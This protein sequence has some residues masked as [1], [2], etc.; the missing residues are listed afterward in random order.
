MTTEHLRRNQLKNPHA[1]LAHP[2]PRWARTGFSM[3]LR[4][5]ASALEHGL[6]LTVKLS[7]P[8]LLTNLH[9]L[10]HTA[11]QLQGALATQ[12]QLQDLILRPLWTLGIYDTGFLP[13][14]SADSI[15]T[16]STITR[17]SPAAGPDQKRA[18]NLLTSLLCCPGLNLAQAAMATT[19]RPLQAQDRKRSPCLST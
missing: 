10:V 5:A 12:Q 4:K 3:M 18:V 13:G 14:R 11:C 9:E 1:D 17:K 8:R 7:S 19:G 6:Q 16:L 2:H 15:L